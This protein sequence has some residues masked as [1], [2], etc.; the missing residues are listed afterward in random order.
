MENYVLMDAQNYTNDMSEIYRE[1]VRGIIFVGG[2][3][4]LVET[5]R[6]EVK[7][8]GGGIENGET[9]EQALLR[10]VREETGR[11]VI[12]ESIRF[13]TTIDE[14]RA[15]IK[16][17]AIYHQVSRLFFCEVDDNLS[18]THYSPGEIRH[19]LHSVNMTLDEAI[20]ANERMLDR[21]G[22]HPW[23]Q[24]EYKTFLLLKEY[25]NKV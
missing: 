9:D 15:S 8:P 5:D 24:R 7:L 18:E 11:N 2:K 12:P 14:K 6:G 16:E 25:M 23:N 4:L 13:W 21:E 1:A 10:E 19:H 17:Y 3:M 22:R 20:E